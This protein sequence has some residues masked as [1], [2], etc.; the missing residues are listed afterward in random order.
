MLRIES[1]NPT[2]LFKRSDDGLLQAV[3][4][5]IKNTSPSPS[6]GAELSFA[7]PS[8]EPV[9][10]KLDDIAPKTSTQRVMVP[11]V[12]EPANVAVALKPVRGKGDQQPVAWQ[13]RKHWEIHLI[14]IAH[15]DYGYTDPIEDILHFYKDLYTKVADYCEA[16]ADYPEEAQFHYNCEEAWSLRYFMNHSDDAAIDKLAKYVVEGRVEIPALLGNE[17]SG[18]CAHEELVRLAYPS[19]KLQER[20]GGEI[21]VGSITDVPGLSWALPTVLAGVGVKY[22]FPGLPHY[23]T[24][25]DGHTSWDE[26]AVMREHGAPDA[27]WWEG[28]DGSKVLVFY[29]GGYGGFG[30]PQ[31]TD[32]VMNTLPPVLEDLEAKGNPFSV[33]R[34]AAYGCGDNTP[35]ST[36]GCEVA[37]EWNSTW[38]F[39]KLRISTNTKFFKALEP[40]CENLRTFRGELPHTDYAV[41]AVS[42]A[43]ETSLNR[44]TRDYLPA[45]ERFATIASIDNPDLLT[46]ASGHF[47]DTHVMKLDVPE[48]G[49]SHRIEDAYYDMM[50][51]D[52]HTWGMWCPVGSIQDFAWHDKARHAY[53]AAST[54]TIMGRRSLN[55]IGKGIA[56]EEG[57][58][59]VV[60]NPL[61]NCRSDVVQVNGLE[62]DNMWMVNEQQLTS[63]PFELIDLA[64]GKRVPYQLVEIDSAQAPVSHAAGRV[65][66]GTLQPPL[67]YDLLFKAEDV[68]PVGYKTFRIKPAEKAPTVESALKVTDCSVENEFFRV[69][70]NAK[71]GLV[72][73]VFDKQLGRELMDGEAD[74]AANQLVVKHAKAARL[75]TTAKAKVKIGQ[76]GPIM[77]SLLIT[78]QAPGCPQVTQEIVLQA[79]VKRV[80]FNNRVLK[81]STPLLELYFAFPFKVD[82]PK[83][84]FEGT[85]SVIRPFVDQFPG[86]NTNYYSVQHWA[87]VSDGQMSVTL[88]PVDSHLVEFGGMHPFHVSP[89]HRNVEPKDF[90]QGFV[91]EA[92]VTKGHMYSLVLASN[93]CT[94]FQPAQQGD[95]LFRYS[96]TTHD[97]DWTTGEPRDF[98]WARANPLM[99]S[100]LN[101]HSEGQ[102]PVTDSFCQIDAS[103]AVLTS[104]KHAEDGDGLVLRL[105]ETEGKATDATVQLPFVTISEALATDLVERNGQALTC[106]AHSVTVPVKA[107]GIA[108][109][110]LRVGQH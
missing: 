90:K 65:G 108:T 35:T 17:I 107:F 54:T 42:T 31:S 26:P 33:F 72:E 86:S 51:F 100:V 98:G 89:A 71:S 80:D 85:N 104:L 32:D 30:S 27:F 15:H 63:K 10:Y 21:C 38:A 46:P 68:P 87:N 93:F 91:A 2:V 29:Q 12:R 103:N 96:L 109:V 18:M 39:P 66:M 64:T 106:D 94:N 34:A 14:P 101:R 84:T 7:F 75:K 48:M 3:D 36:I 9:V 57:T 49:Q 8:R 69:T 99:A 11:D 47:H 53:R 110:R 82:Q 62:T 58:H 102:R 79:G 74:H 45:V 28:P 43:K 4:V 1:V 19:R 44:I 97:G 13:P 81:D 24:W 92:D 23:F 5:T 6:V 60:F 56:R 78:S 83:F 16:T 25:P 88:T 52:E 22:F 73:S 95:L 41:G 61:T 76:T 105:V 37:R 67:K 70:V 50:M 20:L 77:A 59:I 55:S 40:Q